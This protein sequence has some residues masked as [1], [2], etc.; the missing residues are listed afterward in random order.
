MLISVR[1][2]GVEPGSGS[3]TSTKLYDIQL[4]N[5]RISAVQA[6]AGAA[7]A[8]EAIT[9]LPQGATLTFHPQSPTG[10]A[11]TPVTQSFSCQ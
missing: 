2:S 1:K 11:G 4:T 10:G 3:P 9:L 8:S 7:D 5:V 6:S